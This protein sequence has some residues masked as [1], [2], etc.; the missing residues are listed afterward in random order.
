MSACS[1][2]QWRREVVGGGGLFNEQT[3]AK[4]FMSVL[5]GGEQQVESGR[6]SFRRQKKGIKKGKQRERSSSGNP[7]WL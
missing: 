5:L 6:A 3:S 2:K 7:A 1:L 4:I